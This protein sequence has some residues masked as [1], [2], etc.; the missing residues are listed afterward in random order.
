MY[1]YLKV[2]SGGSILVLQYLPDIL[3]GTS[4]WSVCLVQDLYVMR[5]MFKFCDEPARRL[6]LETWIQ[7]L[8]SKSVYYLDG[9][10]AALSS[11]S[12]DICT[13]AYKKPKGT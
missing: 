6:M 7:F 3:F 10:K 13:L 11:I 9:N 2:H 8:R 4:Q 1:S 12:E 5:L